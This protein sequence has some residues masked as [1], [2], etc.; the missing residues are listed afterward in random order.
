SAFHAQTAALDPLGRFATSE[1]V[2]CSTSAP[3][4]ICTTMPSPPTLVT[5]LLRMTRP[6]DGV[7]GSAS[8]SSGGQPSQ[9]C[10]MRHFQ[11]VDMLIPDRFTFSTT[12]FS[13]DTSLNHVGSR[14]AGSSEA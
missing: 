10:S 9:P 1:T 2:L 5:V 6:V 4:F 12:L 3:V 13:I 7:Q 11:A 14:S 8:R